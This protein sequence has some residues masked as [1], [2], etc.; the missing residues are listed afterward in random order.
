M[1][2]ELLVDGS[3]RLSV[4]RFGHTSNDCEHLKK[5]NLVVEMVMEM[6]NPE[7]IR[8]AVQCEPSIALS[9][10]PANA[11]SRHK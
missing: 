6:K 9:D 2:V 3:E 4:E 7:F 5:S 11:G 10:P 8:V 1:L